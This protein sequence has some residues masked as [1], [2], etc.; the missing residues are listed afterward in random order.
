[1]RAK[2]HCHCGTTLFRGHCQNQRCPDFSPVP[3]YRVVAE[4]DGEQ[5]VLTTRLLS[6]DWAHTEAGRIIDSE[7]PVRV[8]AVERQGA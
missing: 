5:H 4:A 8:L 2:P 3:M 7:S 1:V 6:P